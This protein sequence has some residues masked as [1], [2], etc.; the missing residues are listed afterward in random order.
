MIQVEEDSEYRL[1]GVS[2]PGMPEEQ[3]MGQYK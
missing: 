2:V 3:N 1:Y